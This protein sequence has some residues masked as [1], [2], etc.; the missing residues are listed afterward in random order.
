MLAFLLGGML[1]LTYA[2]YVLVVG[3]RVAACA[4]VGFGA[5]LTVIIFPAVFGVLLLR[6]GIP[7]SILSF[8][9]PN[10]ISH[11]EA[12]LVG[13]GLTIVLLLGSTLIGS[14]FR[15]GIALSDQTAG[16]QR[17]IKIEE[18][19]KGMGLPLQERQVMVEKVTALSDAALQNAGILPLTC[20]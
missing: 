14:V 17:R 3:P 12:M 20:K 8:Q 19:V 4:N 7:G 9:R 2:G 6:I 15:D 18:F 5:L 10:A 16:L 1:S 13:L 11:R